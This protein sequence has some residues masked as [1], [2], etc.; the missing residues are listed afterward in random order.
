MKLPLIAPLALAALACG[1][2]RKPAAAPAPARTAATGVA[3]TPPAGGQDGDIPAARLDSINVSMA[4]VA[5]LAEQVFGDGTAAAEEPDAH[6]EPALVDEVEIDGEPMAVPTWDIDV[7]S[8]ETHARVE[9][10]VNLFSGAASDRMSKRLT[11]G[12]RYDAMIRSKFR[13][14]GIPED[15][16]YLALIESGYNPHAYSRAAAVGMWQFMASTA[17]GAGLR[18]DWWVDERRDPVRSTDAAITFLSYLRGQLGSLYL[19]AAAYNGGPGRVSRGLTRF[20][21]EMEGTTGDDRFFALAEKNYLPAETKNYVPQLIAAALVGKE[22]EKYGVKVDMLEPYAYDSVRVGAFT[23][24]AAVGRA[25]GASNEVMKDLNSHLLRGVTP[26]GG[27]SWVRVPVGAH[28]GFAESYARLPEGARDPFKTVVAKKRQSLAAIART[29]GLSE[30]QLSWYNPGLKRL[31]SGNLRPGQSVRVPSPSVVAL[32]LDVPDPSVERY[33]RS[34]ATRIHIVKRGESL[35]LIA[36]RNGTTVARL[37]ALNGLRRTTVFP[38]QAL[39]VKGSVPKAAAR[40]GAKPA[41]TKAAARATGKGGAKAAS[42][43][44]G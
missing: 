28:E 23:P 9:H 34:A 19:A 12:T 22:P 3:V 41:R 42:A 29:H 7:R 32:A 8:Y 13:A 1:G 11:R 15:M 33:G 26:P 44:G 25:V 17:R 4:E 6:E 39:V 40:R 27:S 5:R 14:A 36:K 18:V 31:K 43:R 21:D 30:R 35:G 37:K 20:A 38:G 24:V 16:T 2:T 10:Y